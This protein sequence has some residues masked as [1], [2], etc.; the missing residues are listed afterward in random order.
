MAPTGATASSYFGERSPLRTID[1]SGMSPAGPV[2]V[3]STASSRPDEPFT[4]WLTDGGT[5]AAGSWITFDMGSVM[6]FN[7][8]HLW[9]YNENAENPEYYTLS[10]IQEAEVYYGNSPLDGSFTGTLAQSYSFTKATGEDTYA[11][12]DYLFTTPVTGRYIQIKVLSH[13]VGGEPDYV[14][15]S[16]IRFDRAV[17][18]VASANSTDW[19]NPN[20]WTPA[21]VPTADSVVTVNAHA[22]TINSAQSTTPANCYSLTIS[23]VGGSVTAT[24]QSLTVG[25]DLNTTS[26]ALTLDG[27]STLSVVTANTSASLK[28]LTVGSGTILNITGELTVDASKDLTGA[29]LS[30]PKV[31][32][33]GGS[34]L[35]IG[36]LDVPDAGSLTGTGS[37]ASTVTV[38][39]GGKIAPGTDATI[40]TITASGLSLDGGSLLT[41]NAA[42][43]SN[44][45]Q[46]TVGTSG[47][48]TINGGAIT[49]LNATGTAGESFVGTYKLIAYSGTIGGTGVS[50]LTV[51]NPASNKEYAF[52]ATGTFV[53]LTVTKKVG[54]LANIYTESFIGNTPGGIAVNNAGIGWTADDGSYAVLDGNSTVVWPGAATTP[55]G[56]FWYIA[57]G[58]GDAAPTIVHTIGGEYTILDAAR[59]GTQFKVDWASGGTK[60]MRFIA[61]V[62]SKWYVT[63]IMGTDASLHGG[64]NGR[65]VTSWVVDQ[66]VNVE[67][68]TWYEWLDYGKAD[69]VS[70]T[71]LT[72][73]PKGDIPQFGVWWMTDNNSDV[74]AMDHFRVEASG[75][76]SWAAT[77]AG[78]QAANLDA[79]NDGVA[80]GV[81]Y[82]MNV[83]G[84]TTNP[85][86]DGTGKVTWPNGGNIPSS[87]Y[88]ADKQFVVQTS[89]NLQTWDNVPATG[90]PKLSNQSGSVSYT[91]TLTDPGP[92]FVRLKV[93]PN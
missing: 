74:Y 36:A 70:S 71:P 35:T 82:F 85:A 14:G 81:A 91:L 4:M 62:G 39:S 93:T 65:K 51:A 92:R 27:T 77:N 83:T 34:T 31:T 49:L 78:G 2:T 38:A 46:I 47:G 30:T 55:D 53:T 43:D 73:L 59:V 52:A 87:E 18:P 61:A 13:F 29:T 21:A 17:F 80:N 86:I 67:T 11:G 84:L 24:G 50:S 10:G 16:E 42:S 66:T 8:F 28:G 89:S 9:N 25:G 58:G 40:S 90:D 76:A 26:G 15:I 32:L 54:A 7:G 79:N 41:I 22:V 56:D 5:V 44:H 48:L 19:N 33:A 23:G 6:T 45:D 69:Q 57:R 12:A 63:G 20:T 37:V 1:G 60:G 75:Y 72:G 64:M 68:A 88:G 3:T